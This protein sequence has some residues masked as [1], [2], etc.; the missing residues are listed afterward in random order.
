MDPLTN[1]KP[2][3]TKTDPQK[4][5]ATLRTM[6]TDVATFIQKERPSL[7]SMVSRQEDAPLLERKTAARPS[8]LSLLATFLI[9]AIFGML[10]YTGYLYYQATR[11]IVEPGPGTTKFFSTDKKV[12]HTVQQDRASLLKVLQEESTERERDGL[13]KELSLSLESAVITRTLTPHQFFS[14]LAI[15]TP[16]GFLDELDVEFLPFLFYTKG[17]T[18]FGA[19]ARAKNTDA[20]FAKLLEWEV[21]IQKDLKPLL[22]NRE[23]EVTI[24]LFEDKTY[25]NVHYRFVQLSNETDFGI[26]YFVFPTKSFVIIGTSEEELRVVIN[27]LFE[28]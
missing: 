25:K 15:K 8:A 23:A 12:S 11:V 2:E 1:H 4:H 3:E 18:Y 22:F 5:E 13:V 6:K 10:G 28:A 26:G 21:S 9:I 16:K 19:V 7:I 24:P 17:E 27:R 20:A 14:L